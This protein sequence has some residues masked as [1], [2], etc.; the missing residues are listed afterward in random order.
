MG[1]RWSPETQPPKL[2]LGEWLCI[3]RARAGIS[4]KELGADLGVSGAL[5]SQWEAD[6]SLPNVEQ[7]RDITELCAAHWLWEAVKDGDVCMG[8]EAK[9]VRARQH[10]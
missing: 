8:P 6:D 9:E 5:V 1:I 2:T 10:T 7:F 4:R 3:V